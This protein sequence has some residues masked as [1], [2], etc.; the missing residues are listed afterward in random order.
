VKGGE[1]IL[2]DVEVPSSEPAV[3]TEVVETHG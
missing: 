1:T 3:P 2:A